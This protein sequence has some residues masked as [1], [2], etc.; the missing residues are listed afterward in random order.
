MCFV[1]DLVA[2]FEVN[3]RRKSLECRIKNRALEGWVLGTSVSLPLLD[4]SQRA[5]WRHD[6]IQNEPHQKTTTLV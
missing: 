2:R 3:C 6:D 1:R 5:N 4:H